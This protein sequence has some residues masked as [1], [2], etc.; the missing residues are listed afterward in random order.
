MAKRLQRGEQHNDKNRE[1]RQQ[2]AL[3]VPKKQVKIANI[4]LVVRENNKNNRETD[5]SW[6]VC[7]VVTLISNNA[8]E[9]TKEGPTYQNPWHKPL[10]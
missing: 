1:D 6:L 2:K 4:K 3:T 9:T 8:D 7:C 10:R 5:S